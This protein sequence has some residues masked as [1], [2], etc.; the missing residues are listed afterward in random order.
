MRIAII[1]TVLWFAAGTAAR[2]ENCVIEGGNTEAAVAHN[3]IIS[4]RPAPLSIVSKDFENSR[5]QDGTWRHQLFVQ[6]GKPMTLFLAACGDGVVDV[7]GSP[8]P[9]G[10]AEISDKSSRDNCVGHRMFNIAPG[11]LAIWVITS[12]EDTKF[13]LHPVVR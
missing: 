8:W 2:A 3:C 11:R 4:P 10:K 12:A 6:I 9:A 7:G 13:T 5:E 1:A